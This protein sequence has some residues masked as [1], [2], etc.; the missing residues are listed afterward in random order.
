MSSEREAA[1]HL[2]RDGQLE[3]AKDSYIACI[4]AEESRGG[5]QEELAKLYNNLSVCYKALN[6]DDYALQHALACLSLQP[7]HAKANL[8][9]AVLQKGH[10]S[11]GDINLFAAAALLGSNDPEVSKMLA[12]RGAPRVTLAKTALELRRACARSGVVVV[13]PGTYQLTHGADL[14]ADVYICPPLRSN[15]RIIGLGDVTFVKGS[16]NAA[17]AAEKSVLRIDNVA[18]VESVDHPRGAAFCVTG[19][20]IILSKCKFRGVGGVH[21]HEFGHAQVEDCSFAAMTLQAVEVSAGGKADIVRSTFCECQRGVTVYGGAMRVD[22]RDCTFI[23]SVEQALMLD[24]AKPPAAVRAIDG[25]N[26]PA[27]RAAELANKGHGAEYDVHKR[28][29][30]VAQDTILLAKSNGLIGQLACRVERCLIRGSGLHAIDCGDGAK[31]EL[32]ACTVEGARCDK[33]RYREL[34]R[35]QL[36]FQNPGQPKEAIEDLVTENEKRGLLTYGVGLHVRGGAF[37]R[38]S[39]CVFL[40]NDTGINIDYNFDGDVLL[41]HC[42]F[43]GNDHDVKQST[44]D[45]MN[46]SGVTMWSRPARII[47][48]R[49]A[50]S[51]RDVPTMIKLGSNAIEEAHPLTFS[52]SEKSTLRIGANPTRFPAFQLDP[53]YYPIGNTFGKDMLAI[54]PPPTSETSRVILLACGDARN[55]IETIAAW[56]QRNVSSSRRLELTLNDVCSSVLIR[57]AAL[58]EL[59]SRGMSPRVLADVWGSAG[60]D[61]FTLMALLDSLRSV[62]IAGWLTR[63]VADWEA[64]VEAW[65]RVTTSSTEMQEILHNQRARSLDSAHLTCGAVGQQ[66]FTEV[67]SY[68]NGLIFEGRTPTHANPTLLEG[69]SLRPSLYFSSSIFRSIG[70]LDAQPGSLREALLGRLRTLSEEVGAAL[71]SGRVSINLISGD[72]FDVVDKIKTVCNFEL[73]D[74]VD[75]TNVA[76]YVG[77]ANTLLLGA[78]IGSRVNSQIMTG[79]YDGTTPESFFRSSFGVDVASFCNL[80]SLHLVS[81]KVVLSSARTA[82]VLWTEWEH[83]EPSRS[84]VWSALSAAAV[85][86]HMCRPCGYAD[87]GVDSSTSLTAAALVGGIRLELL[88]LYPAAAEELRLIDGSCILHMPAIADIFLVRMHLCHALAVV[89]CEEPQV[90]GKVVGTVAAYLNLVRWNPDEEEAVFVAPLDLQDRCGMLFAS[91]A[92]VK[93]DAICL[94]ESIQV[95]TMRNLGTSPPFQLA[96]RLTDAPRG[97]TWSLVHMMHHTEAGAGS[98]DSLIE[99]DVTTPRLRGVTV[100]AEGKLAVFKVGQQR[101]EVDTGLKL[102]NCM[103]AACSG[104]LGLASCAFSV[105]T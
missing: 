5:D 26:K 2:Y 24:G 87:G 72:A 76:D 103:R 53:H 14:D 34:L 73:A 43:F 32:I 54:E 10:G 86:K 85:A 40:D 81:S 60:L 93:N 78:A 96:R 20:S 3:D 31:L 62:T 50:N 17:D 41:D 44:N 63:D 21:V 1:N 82:S 56:W 84:A 95:V 36:R 79:L 22:I 68:L 15:V 52:S 101:F 28:R 92:L 65:S 77:L 9:A 13:A 33:A 94:S 39:Q 7:M 19:G 45:T 97:G 18:V 69:A 51:L 12:A 75:T 58:L 37:A 100:C 46:D 70:P 57:N 104:N 49:A 25:R 4:Q 66:H 102:H 6:D 11:S 99:I 98:I 30:E 55:A 48:K 64:V 29:L 42:T 89:L 16:C 91:L 71:G 27:A 74:V 23:D 83:C 105:S 90:V 80:A 67:S 61:E 38:A 35:Q 8:R 59:M 88:D 47:E